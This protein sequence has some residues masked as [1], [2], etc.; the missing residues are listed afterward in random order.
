[1]PWLPRAHVPRKLV[2]RHSPRKISTI[3][4]CTPDRQKYSDSATQCGSHFDMSRKFK[5]IYISRF[6][7]IYLVV[8]SHMIVIDP[9]TRWYL[10]TSLLFLNYILIAFGGFSPIYGSPRRIHDSAAFCLNSTIGNTSSSLPKCFNICLCNSRFSHEQDVLAQTDL[11][12]VNTE[13]KHE[14]I[15]NFMRIPMLQSQFCS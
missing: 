2:A 3:E 8:D 1:M 5:E 10:R 4:L 9:S 14:W 15:F 13:Q 7:N 12:T 6:T 11:T